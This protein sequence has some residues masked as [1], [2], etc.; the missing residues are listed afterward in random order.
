M[1]TVAT[2]GKTSGGRESL[3]PIFKWEEIHAQVF[4]LGGCCRRDDG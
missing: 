3:P 2:G 4:K 1:S